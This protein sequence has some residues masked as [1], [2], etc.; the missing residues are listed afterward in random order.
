MSMMG[1]AA[2]S[3]ELKELLSLLDRHKD[4]PP[5]RQIELVRQWANETIQAAESG[6]L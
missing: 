4:D 6:Y 5:E 1:S 3:T 2:V